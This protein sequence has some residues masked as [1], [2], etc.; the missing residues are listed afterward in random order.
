MLGSELG[1][2]TVDY[3]PIFAAAKAAGLKHYFAEQEGPFSRM[4][5]L[6]AAQAAFD[7]LHSIN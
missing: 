4:G 1:R 3:R 2:G 6:E 7:Y 5:Q